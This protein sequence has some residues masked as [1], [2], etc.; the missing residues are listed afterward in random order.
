M[1]HV[2]RMSSVFIT[3]ILK[4]MVL[5]IIALIIHNV[6]TSRCTWCP[7]GRTRIQSAQSIIIS[8]SDQHIVI[9]HRIDDLTLRS[10]FHFCSEVDSCSWF[11]NPLTWTSDEKY[12]NWTLREW[13]GCVFD[14][15]SEQPFQ[16][17]QEKPKCS[18]RQWYSFMSRSGWLACAPNQNLGCLLEKLYNAVPTQH[19]KRYEK[20][21]LKCLSVCYRFDW[22]PLPPIRLRVEAALVGSS[23]LQSSSTRSICPK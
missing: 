12:W 19:R 22:W 15:I 21:W 1:I 10:F 17:H 11:G 6:L 7:Q 5:V 20:V 2:R 18:H 14:E 8:T 23:H 9:T 4:T 13:S 16:I 3:P